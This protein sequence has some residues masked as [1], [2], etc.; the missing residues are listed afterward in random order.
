ML[1]TTYH[2]AP[3]LQVQVTLDHQQH[4]PYLESIQVMV[5]QP[6]Q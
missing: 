2:G 3:S 1:V 6:E 5:H 4:Q